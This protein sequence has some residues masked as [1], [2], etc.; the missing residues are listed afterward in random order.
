MRPIHALRRLY[1]TALDLRE[2]ARLARLTQDLPVL[3]Q[4]EELPQWLNVINLRGQGVEIGVQRATFS[5]ILLDHWHGA[6]L[7]SVDP[8]RNFDDPEY[9]D[10]ANAPDD[11]HE[12]YFRT[13][14]DRLARF[15]NRSQIHRLTSAEAAPQFEDNSLDFV[16][17][18]AQHHYEAVIEDLTLWAPKVRPGGVIAGHDYLDGEIGGNRFGVKQAVDEF[19][20]NLNLKIGATL[21]AEFPTWFCRLPS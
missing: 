1:R 17:I 16:Y 8:W 6:C 3:I 5:T 21:E 14:S 11:T 4:R 7:H 19:A 20:A 13:A 2:E 12:R 15:G 18:D 10:H 9:V